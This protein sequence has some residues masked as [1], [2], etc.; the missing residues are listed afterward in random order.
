MR[1]ASR[2]FTVS[3]WYL[4]VAAWLSLALSV[5]ALGDLLGNP[6][7]MDPLLARLVPT[8]HRL[9]IDVVAGDTSVIDLTA[10][11]RVA[12]L[13]GMPQTPPEGYARKP[14]MDEFASGKAGFVA[15]ARGASPGQTAKTQRQFLDAWN[16][17]A[18]ENRVFL[19]FTAADVG[20]ARKV[21]RALRDEGYVT[22]VFLQSGQ[23]KPQY[24]A[25]LVGVMF[26]Q[27]GHHL[28][29][30][31]ASARR[32]HGV[33][34][35]AILAND[36]RR[37]DGPPGPEPGGVGSRPKP[38]PG[39]PGPGGAGASAG[40]QRPPAP[41]ADGQPSPPSP[42]ELPVRQAPPGGF[43]EQAFRHGVSNQWV[44]TRNPSTP[45]KLFIH[46]ESSGGALRGLLYYVKVESDGSW[47]V[48]K[49]NGSTAGS[50]KNPPHVSIGLCTCY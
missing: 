36:F 41:V 39:K 50:L 34:F 4:F 19:S 25:H 43:D 42:D 3:I 2:K 45:G 12:L 30:D 33:W 5:P 17:A 31:T 13:N 49:P 47:T 11:P 27:A 1:L 44:V 37:P 7:Y 26:A 16:K 48:Q 10:R 18:P 22:F 14:W 24:D 28:V 8:L 15:G 32:S 6:A 9:K 21:A 46:R 35:E 40:S 20:E 23:A 38:P 29:L